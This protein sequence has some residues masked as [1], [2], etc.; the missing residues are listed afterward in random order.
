MAPS[1]SEHDQHGAH[2]ARFG[3]TRAI[4]RVGWQ[5]AVALILA[6]A[7]GTANAQPPTAIEVRVD[8]GTADGKLVFV[9]D[10]FRFQR[11]K[12]YKLVIHNPSAERHYFSAE[13]LSS[14]VFSR[15]TE[16]LDA[17]GEVLAEVHGDVRD[18]ELF[19]G[20]TVAWYFY[21]MSKGKDLPIICHKPGHTEAGMTGLVEIYG[22]PPFQPD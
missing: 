11:G 19:P 7:F 10:S 14:R 3:G 2:D 22:P 21:P 18:I 17:N 15:K 8:A 13:G 4:L 9:P 20:S 12:L 5:S 1:T 16:T 6:S